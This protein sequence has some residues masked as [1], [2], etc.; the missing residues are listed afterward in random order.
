MSRRFDTITIEDLARFPR[1]GTSVPARI[2]FTPDGSALTYLAS[3]EGNLV[4]SLFS[5]DFASGRRSVLAGPPEASTA[6]AALSREEELRRE[7]ARLR[8]LGV[9]SYHFA[10]NA[11]RPTVL[12][13][14]GGSLRVSID[15][16]EPTEIP[17]TQGALDARLSRDGKRVAFV[18]DGELHV[19]DVPGGNV[20]QLTSGAE[21]GLTNGVADFI[22]AEELGRSEGF[23]WSPDGK[24]IA[25]VR[26]DSRHI[27][28]F[29]IVHQ[30]SDA[31]DV[32]HHRYPFAGGANAFVELAVVDVDSGETRWMD[33]GED[34]DI[35]LARVTW[36]P[37][38][39]LT[40]QILS[41]D[42]QR[43]R[44]VAFSA[45]G[46]A[47]T[48]LEEQSEPW[49]NLHDDLRFLD[50]GRF[51]WSS[52]QTGFRHVYLYG[53]DGD[54]ERQLTSGEW[55]VT[56]VVA[57]DEANGFAYFEGTRDSVLERHL[58]RIPLDG[59][60]PERLTAPGGWHSTVVSPTAG[61]MVDVHS[62][63]DHAPTVTLRSL[64]GD[65]AP[66][67]I[68]AN[69]GASAATLGLEPP[70]LMEFAAA[71]GA[72][73]HGA[74]YAPPTE[75][76]PVPLVVSV[77]GG[78]H[79]Q[80]V[81]DEWS[82]T[83]DLRA[84]YLARMG[85][86]VLKVDNRGSANRGLAFEAHLHRAMGTVEVEDQAA[87]V[88]QLIQ[89]GIVDPQRVG[90]LGWSY[91]GY[92][93][94]LCLMLQPDLFKVGVAG[95]PVTDWDGYDTGYT[96]RYMSTPQDN[97]DGYRN[98][99]ALTHASKLQGKLMLVHGGVDENVHFRHTARLIGA[100]TRAQKDF[101]LLLFPEERHM[102]R[103][104]AGLKYQERRLVEYF[105]SHL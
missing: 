81:I 17:G 87:A 85:F 48:L 68:F 67:V 46:A 26:A 8:E 13:P 72:T 104:A 33:L 3:A 52:E 49:L 43:I 23:W 15:G 74:Y 60:E 66:I 58:Y 93:S 9:T 102:P 79:A 55:V 21:D 90:I 31:V 83:V 12:I 37:D 86:G 20:R 94:C 45:D 39:V 99:S 73:M 41:R 75:D 80:R 4:L 57:V 100:L 54:L 101:D 77:Y 7:R 18:R 5:Y 16:A 59:G 105:Q 84:Q 34:R 95:A 92:M 22:A 11:E 36:R 42:Q 19:A 89:R 56:R 98:G 78:P 14:V 27:P 64:S 63:R 50:D 30:G 40:A 24:S 97:P 1:P 103:D 10:R 32:E 53:R 44:L 25:F 2:G 96:E 29:P 65:G 61:Y 51:I 62:T 70:A 38:G 47:I 28:S 82:L 69:E 91:G 76:G 88:R 6:E 71:D 35:Y